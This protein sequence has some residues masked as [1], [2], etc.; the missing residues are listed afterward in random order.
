MTPILRVENLSTHF[1]TRGGAVRAVDD[2]SFDVAEGETVGIVGE[3]GCGKSA[4]VLSIMKLI[5]SPPGRIVGGNIIFPPKQDEPGLNLRE[6]NESQMQKVRGNLVSMVCQ[7]PMTSLNPVLTIGWQ[8]REP[9]QLHLGMTK[10]E[11]TDRSIELLELVN[12]PSPQQRLNDYPHQFSGG[13]RQR[14]MIAMAIACNPKLLIADE[15]TTALDVTIQAQILELLQKLQEELN[16]SVVIITHDLGV[17]GEICDRVIVM[18]AGH[19]IESGSVDALLDTPKHPYTEGLLKSV[20]KL[21]P[22]VKDR[23]SPIEGVP[24]NLISLPP[25]CRFAPRCP[26]RFE[27]CETD[28]LLK[29]L[30]QEHEHECACWL[31]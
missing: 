30:E 7:D 8:L 6:F 28:P 9:L 12:I 18:Y 16:M 17:V 23:M 31:Y 2:V 29:T 24:P 1:F 19:I 27:Q 22:S 21:G 3:S 20:P 14:V 4:T 5:P 13:M 15:P 25:G 26:S 10:K 11:A